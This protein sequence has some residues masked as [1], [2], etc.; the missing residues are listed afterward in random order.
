[1]VAEHHDGN[2]W[3]CMRLPD[4]ALPNK[5]RPFSERSLSLPL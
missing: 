4:G 3:V 5:D 2:K 1:M